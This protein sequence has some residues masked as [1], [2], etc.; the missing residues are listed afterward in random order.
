MVTLLL[1]TLTDPF[2]SHPALSKFSSTWVRVAL[3]SAF[4]RNSTL[5]MAVSAWVP[6]LWPSALRL[7]RCEHTFVAF[8]DIEKAFD[9]WVEATLVRL[10]DF[11]VTGRL[12]HLLANFLCGTLSQAR[13]GGSVS[14]PWVDSGIAQGRILSSLLFKLLIDSLAVTLRSAIPTFRHACQ[15]CADDLVVLTA[16]QADLQMALDAVYAWGVRWRFFFGIGHGLW[17]SARPP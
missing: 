10:F 5:S 16:S 6:T 3:L 7:R 1:L 17:S 8:I 13:L 12:W 11:G 15:L 4:F 14:S 2:L 9:S